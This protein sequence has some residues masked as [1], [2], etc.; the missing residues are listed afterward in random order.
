MEMTEAERLKYLEINPPT[1][2]KHAIIWLHGL[3]ADG[4][5]FV[6]IA[7]QLQIPAVMATRFVFPHAPTL[8]VTINQG[9]RMP[10]WYDIIS[11]ASEG[12]I[13]YEG[14]A[15]SVA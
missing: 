1:P 8:P 7:P 14:I 5:D 12:K 2:A 4:S 15:R 13:D 10:A 6:P 9:H 3:G 11:I